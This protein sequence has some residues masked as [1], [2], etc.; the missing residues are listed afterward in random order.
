MTTGLFAN[1]PS[2]TTQSCVDKIDWG[3]DSYGPLARTRLRASPIKPSHQ[4]EYTKKAA[5][6]GRLFY[7]HKKKN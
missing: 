7:T 6:T 2:S 3:A 4:K 5:P 1:N